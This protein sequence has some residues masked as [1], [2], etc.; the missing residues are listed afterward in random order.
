[1]EKRKEKDREKK[2]ERKGRKKRERRR[3]VD[4]EGVLYD[5]LDLIVHRWREVSRVALVLANFSPVSI[6]S[7]INLPLIRC[8]KREASHSPSAY[9]QL[10]SRQLTGG[11]VR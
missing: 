8:N 3:A 6:R 7:A 10:R 4:E 11:S 5:E 2:T 9:F 1:M